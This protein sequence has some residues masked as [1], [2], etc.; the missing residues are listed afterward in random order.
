MLIQAAAN[1]WQC[2]PSDCYAEDGHVIDRIKGRRLSYGQLVEEARQL[3][4]PEQPT[5]TSRK[6]FQVLG[7]S[8][9]RRD[10][11]EK[12]NGRALFGIDVTVPGMLYASIERSPVFLGTVVRFN[13]D[14]ARSIPGVV[15][16]LK[17]SRIVWGEEREGL[18]VVAKTYWAAE[19]GRKLLDITWD[20]KGLNKYSTE[21]LRSEYAAVAGQEGTAFRQEGNPDAVFKT[22]T[23]IEATY[24]LPYQAHAC[25]EPMNAVVSVADGRC[26]FWGSTQN[27]N[28]V[29]SQLAR[30]LNLP[31]EKVTVHYTY[32]GGGFG[33]RSMTDVAEEAADLS[34]KVKAPVK[35]VWT[36]E[37]DISQG[38][39]RACQRNVCRAVVDSSGKLTA[40]EHKVISQD[41]RN[42]TGDS[43]EPGG[44]IAGGIVT[45][46]AIPNFRI[47]GI[48]RKHYIPITYWR[49][50]Y[51]STNCFAHEGF[52][53]E[54]ARAAKKDPLT[55]RLDMLKDHARY[56][57][58]LETVA[59]QSKWYDTKDKD[60]GRGV[61][62]VERS[63]TFVAMVVTIKR[64]NN[65][66]VISR[67]DASLDCGIVINPDIVRAQTEGAAVMGLTA[68]LKSEITF[69]AGVVQE[70]NFDRYR[71]LMLGECPPIEV[72]IV[73]SDAPP[74]GVG[75][76]GLPTVA[77]ALASAIFDLTGKRFRALP[78]SLNPV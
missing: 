10:A 35:V 73:D 55:F 42:Q 66:I 15:D 57:K 20:D 29:R 52:I 41:I 26:D 60:T 72:S 16:V 77:P 21:S 12:V 53:D 59:K 50:V 45:E 8:L 13:A 56:T 54:V 32:M 62:I 3:P 38:P 5:L 76:A 34:V 7:R 6:D 11:V 4:P 63:G 22:G 31:E 40:L 18:A 74:M 2:K 44:M 71:M 30:Q 25:M 58:V 49:A 9:P 23:V 48:L 19:Q 67:I 65:N 68:A 24:E 75:E 39:F 78:F 33:R 27:P 17:T 64:S 51:H 36:R 47:S 37:D 43:T 46:Y 61:A 69:D 70:T 14:K 28:G 1:R